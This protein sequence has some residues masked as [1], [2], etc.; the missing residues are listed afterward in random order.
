MDKSHTQWVQNL[1]KRY[2]QCQI[3]AAIKVNE[4]QLRFNWLL[5][6]DIV[7]MRVEERWGEGV[8]AQLSK[9]LKKG[10]PQ[11]EGLSVTNLRYCRRFYLLYSQCLVIHPQIEGKFSGDVLPSKH[12]QVG[13][14]LSMSETSPAGTCGG[15]QSGRAYQ[16]EVVA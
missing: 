3:K 7:E 9:D 12:P 16:R 5:G 4:E 10:M 1:V 15:V 13:G 8:I 2:R 14:D 11:V 6:H